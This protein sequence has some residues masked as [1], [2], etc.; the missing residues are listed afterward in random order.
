[1]SA[2]EQLVSASPSACTNMPTLRAMSFCSPAGMQATFSQLGFDL[3]GQTAPAL[4]KVGSVYGESVK[5][6]SPLV[7]PPST[8]SAPP[9][10]SPSPRPYCE[11]ATLPALGPGLL[12]T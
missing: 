5:K 9:S 4:K 6:R 1:M 2:A 10:F 3:S 11:T 12:S 8:P 7:F